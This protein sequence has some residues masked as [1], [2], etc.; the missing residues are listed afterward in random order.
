MTLGI[1]TTTE[2]ASGD[3]VSVKPIEQPIFRHDIERVFANLTGDI[4]QVPPMYSAVK[5]NGKNYMSMHAQVL[6]WNGRNETSTF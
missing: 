6:T 5:V 4:E 2:D 1:A 3:I